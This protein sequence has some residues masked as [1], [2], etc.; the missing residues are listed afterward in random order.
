MEQGSRTTLQTDI[1]VEGIISYLG[2]FY[3]GLE[4][5]LLP[6]ALTFAS[7]D[8]SPKPKSKVKIPTRS[9]KRSD[10]DAVAVSTDTEAIRIRVRTTRPPD[11][12]S[13]TDLFPYAYQL[14]LNDMIDVALSVLPSDAYALLLLTKHDMYESDD[15]DFCCGRAWG[16]SRVA[17]VSSARYEPSLDDVHGVD[18]E[19]VWPASHCRAFVE[20]M[21]GVAEE[22]ETCFRSSSSNRRKMSNDVQT[23]IHDPTAPLAKAVEAH[24]ATL[25]A[26][27]W[28][29][30]NL[31]STFLFRLCR[32]ASHELGHCFGFDHCMYKA[33]VMQGTASVAEDMRQPPYLCPVCEAKLAWAV[34][35]GDSCRNKSTTK[36]RA[37]S[38]KALSGP[39]ASGAE[40][41]DKREA[42]L[43]EWKNGRHAVVRRFCEQHNNAF[44]PLAAW[45]LAFTQSG[46][47]D[48]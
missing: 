23:T 32:T 6:T 9:G 22:P 41:N 28:S 29:H 10:L 11:S 42:E 31:K 47:N 16:A 2:V 8:D 15:D 3:H 12:D 45:S 43:A 34:V 39:K 33:C 36:A 7:W 27:P 21:S 38:G 18:R 44:A 17:I 1:D 30:N 48:V 19:H 24:Q 26:A 13:S 40:K 14:N 20:K 37:R 5:K 35:Q 4:V 25:A 46:V